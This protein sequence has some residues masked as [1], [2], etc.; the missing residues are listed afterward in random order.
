MPL[1]QFDERKLTITYINFTSSYVGGTWQGFA[2]P[3]T[4][5]MRLD[6]F[7]C[8]NTDT[9]DAA[10]TVAYYDGVNRFPIATIAVPAGS[11]V[12]AVAPLD[13]LAA[14][15]GASYHYLMLAQ[16]QFISVS[17]A[18]APAASKTVSLFAMGGSF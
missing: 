4:G 10:L 14:M 5:D 13:V 3:G 18:A 2:G 16:G 9:V 7:T 11:G 1:Q 15:F 8:Q 6:V 12:G 17:L